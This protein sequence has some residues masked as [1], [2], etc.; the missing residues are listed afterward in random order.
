[1]LFFLLDTVDLT[2]EIQLANADGYSK[3]DSI[4]A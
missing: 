4:A 1:M 2:K 3:M